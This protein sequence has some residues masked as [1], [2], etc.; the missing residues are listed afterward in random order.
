MFGFGTIVFGVTHSY[1]VAFIALVVLSG[2]DMVSMYIRGS[3][4]PLVTPDDQLGRVTSVEGVFIGASNELG[5]FESGVAAGLFGV[6]FAIA[7][8]GVATVVIAC[9]YYVFFPSLR[10]IDTFEELERPAATV[11][12]S[13]S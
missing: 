5:A 3:L 11:V 13:G 4:V 10:R 9:A 12:A 2:A 6:P 7:A 8:G 1:A